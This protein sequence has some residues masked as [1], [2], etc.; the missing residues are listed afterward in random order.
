LPPIISLLSPKQLFRQ[1]K[2]QRKAETSAESCF[3]SANPR[4][5]DKSVIGSF[6][7]SKVQ[8]LRKF[9]FAGRFCPGVFFQ[10][11][12]DTGMAQLWARSTLKKIALYFTCMELRDLVLLQLR[13][14]PHNVLLLFY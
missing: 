12:D 11:W 1:T 4:C 10:R 6:G 14:L 7:I 8:C 2:E 13:L 5:F 3:I 9:L